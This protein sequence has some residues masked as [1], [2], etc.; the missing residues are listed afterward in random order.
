[1]AK[2]VI[3]GFWCFLLEDFGVSVDAPTSLMLDSTCGISIARDSVKHELTKHLGVD[4][5]FVRA[6][7]R[8]R[9]LLFSMCFQSYI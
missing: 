3:G 7:V 6:V 4:A 2:V 5:S 9:V 1:M 8:D